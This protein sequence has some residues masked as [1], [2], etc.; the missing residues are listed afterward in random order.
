MRAIIV[1]ALGLV[2]AC[3]ARENPFLPASQ[4]ETITTP[5]NVQEAR[6]NF[7]QQAT[8]LPSRARV[9]QYVTFG[10]Q[11]LDGST[12][13]MRM[14]VGKDIDWHDPLVVSRESLLLRPSLVL[15]TMP[16]ESMPPEPMPPLPTED[17]PQKILKSPS[18]KTLT[19]KEYITFEAGEMRLNVLTKDRLVRHFMVA[20]P[21]KVVLDFERD[22]A[23]YTHTLDVQ[24]DAF[25]TITMGNHNGHYRA[26]ILLDGHY[27]YELKEI[28]GGYEIVLR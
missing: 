27:L 16:P 25:K 22:T 24:K 5:T 6:G 3:L 18:F 28:E 14:D 21:Y 26:A 10:Y 9:L 7:E 15:P 20:H 4:Y 1:I 23:F 11:S 12:E 19:F 2:S 8:T 13:E 17:A